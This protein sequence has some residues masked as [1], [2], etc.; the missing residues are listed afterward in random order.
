MRLLHTADFHAGKTLR[1]HDRTPDIEAA[2]GEIADMAVSE[3]VDAVLVSGDVFDSRNPRP[4]AE[5][6]V[7]GFFEQLHAR[8]VG[9]VVTA[10]NH[11]SA[12]R[13]DNLAGPLGWGG[14]Q[15]IGGLGGDLGGL[16]RTVR[17]RDGDTVQIAAVPYLSE[18]GL[19]RL[20]DLIGGDEASAKTRYRETIRR[21]IAA[22]CA[23]FAPGHGHVLMLHGTLDGARP[24]GSERDFQFDLSK[25][26]TL[27]E[28]DLPAQAGYVALGHIHRPQRVG[29]TP[30]A[31]Y[32]GSVVQLDFGEAEEEKSVRLVDIRPG[33]PVQSHEIALTPRTPLRVVRARLDTLDAALREQADFAG[34]LR[35]VVSGAAGQGPGLRDRVRRE[36]P[37]VLSVE[38]DREELAAAVPPAQRREGHSLREHFAHYY[39]ARHGDL[40]TAVESAFDDLYAHTAEDAGEDPPAED[41]PGVPA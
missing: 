29:V 19:V 21:V 34:L 41:A 35:V 10:G 36:H 4:G 13:M 9:A 33:E 3:R 17:G 30:P 18:R 11:D 22:V 16:M 15:V 26:Y 12:A 37:N 1:G 7:L 24:S 2:L 31:Y 40:P 23:G 38:L 8:G 14:I 6:T 5:A 32:S 20:S 25:G 27:G 39:R 28:A